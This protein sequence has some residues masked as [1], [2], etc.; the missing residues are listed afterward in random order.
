MLSLVILLASA[1]VRH[2]VVRCVEGG[3][4]G[5]AVVGEGRLKVNGCHCWCMEVLQWL[6]L[7]TMSWWKALE[8][9]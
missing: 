2:L 5:G 1:E 8:R 4:G 3:K 9:L 7:K 6:I